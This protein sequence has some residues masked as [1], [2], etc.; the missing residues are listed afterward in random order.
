MFESETGFAS[1]PAGAIPPAI[2]ARFAETARG[3]ARRGT[4]R[5]EEHCT[6]CA[7]PA[8]FAACEFYDPRLDMRCRR[9]AGGFATLAVAGAA[10]AGVMRLSFRQ[11]AKLEGRAQLAG[12]GSPPLLT[13]AEAIAAERRD[14]RAG[15][16]LYGAPLPHVAKLL[17]MR[18]RRRRLAK[19]PKPANATPPSHF[20]AEVYHPG[21]DT[22]TLRLVMRPDS[23]SEGETFEA[24][25]PLAPGYNR[26]TFPLAAIAAR[27]DVAR[28]FL[29]QIMASG[30]ASPGTLF[31]G[32]VD[33]ATLLEDAPT[34]RAKCVVWDLDNT[35]WRGTLIE[36]GLAGLTLNPAAAEAIRQLD[37]RGILHSVAS[38]NN[39]EDAMAALRHF[40]LADY[41]LHP[42]ISWEPKSG[43]VARIAAK[44]N[45]GIDALVFIDDQPF[46]RAEVTAAHPTVTTLDPAAIATLPQNPLFDAPDTAESRTRRQ[47][48]Q[49][50][51]AREDAA[52]TSAGDFAAF[53]A[54]CA[55][56]LTIRPLAA[57]TVPRAHELTQRTNQ[58]N[59]SG[60]RYT[61]AE[62]A[63]L[64]TDPAIAAYVLEAADR[65]GDYGIIGFAV[66]SR[67]EGLLRDLM[68]SCRI[69]G[70]HID[71]AALAWLIGAHG[72]G[73]QFHALYR[74]TDRNRRAARVLW[75][76]G[77]E[78]GGD[79][80]G[81]R[82]LVYDIAAKGVPHEEAVT[83]TMTG[84]PAA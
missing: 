72:V 15:A 46:E 52:A 17:A 21:A 49:T 74:E 58:M 77:F 50:E 43:A 3:V 28:G 12:P 76:I 79:G 27:I 33:F 36:D 80:D 22:V 60:N 9:F 7:M 31:F 42:E 53:L 55:L 59:F 62:I 68:F 41:F 5:W 24:A 13:T 23:P 63:A 16:R 66:V 37:T 2:A 20:I 67:G 19:P 82:R 73:G 65:F 69:Q 38:K 75:D 44:L 35:L 30:D 14:A 54:S 83:V 47:L 29:V 10:V 32:L 4:I 39:P 48:Y 84:E 34:K 6:E 70:K 64:A 26:F 1:L 45:I 61:Q 40:G 25:M 51:L 78:P 11:W 57:A 8:C 81:T 18:A 56:R 71:R